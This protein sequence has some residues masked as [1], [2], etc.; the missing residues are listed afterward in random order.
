MASSAIEGA[1]VEIDLEVR[2]LFFI[3]EGGKVKVCIETRDCAGRASLP[4]TDPQ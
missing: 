4:S 2:V 1:R 3:E